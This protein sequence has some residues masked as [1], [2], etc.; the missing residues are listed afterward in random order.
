MDI[1]EVMQKKY[2]FDVKTLDEEEAYM[3]LKFKKLVKDVRKLKA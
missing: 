3:Y 1:I 2:S